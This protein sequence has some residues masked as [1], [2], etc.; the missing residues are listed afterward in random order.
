MRF[1]VTGENPTRLDIKSGK[2]IY[3][4]L[5]G[6][7]NGGNI[8]FGP[9]GMLY[10]CTGDGSPPDPPDKHVTGQD[11][12]DP[13][14]SVLRI[15]VDHPDPGKNF[16]IP[17]DNPFLTTPNALGEVWAYGLRNPWRMAFDPKSGEL[18]A[19]EVGWELWEMIY[20]IVRGG[21]Y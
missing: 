7:H 3:T 9:D 8:R 15:D 1:N 21:N 5:S 18:Y 2:V 11:I 16:G 12:S 17:K 4:W 19:G 13:L 14:S 10:I 6:G 20:R